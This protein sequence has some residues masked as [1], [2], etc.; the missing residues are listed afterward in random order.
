MFLEVSIKLFE[1]INSVDESPRLSRSEINFKTEKYP[2]SILSCESVGDGVEVL[3]DGVENVNGE[4][5]V[6]YIMSD[7]MLYSANMTELTSLG[8]EY[9]LA[10]SKPSGE[11]KTYAYIMKSLT[12]FTVKEAYND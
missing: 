4:I 1:G 9:H 11:F 10:L 5:L 8:A 12:D 2:I 7:G 6:V 3:L